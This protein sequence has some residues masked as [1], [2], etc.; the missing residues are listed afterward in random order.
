MFLMGLEADGQAAGVGDVGVPERREVGKPAA[1]VLERRL[2]PRDNPGNL[3]GI[4]TSFRN[5]WPD[6]TPVTSRFGH[7]ISCR[8][9]IV[10]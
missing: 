10:G 1:V 3:R 7:E 2:R 4:G 8:S 5:P 6:R 9:S